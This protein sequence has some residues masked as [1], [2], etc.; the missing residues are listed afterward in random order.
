MGHQSGSLEAAQ[1]FIASKEINAGGNA[2]RLNHPCH[3]HCA[4]SVVCRAESICRTQRL[5]GSRDR[6]RMNFVQLRA[7]RRNDKTGANISLPVLMAVTAPFLK[8]PPGRLDYH[9]RINLSVQS[10][11]TKTWEQ[12]V[13]LAIEKAHPLFL[14]R[15]PRNSFSIYRMSW[16]PVNIRFILTSGCAAEGDGGMW[17]HIWDKILQ[18]SLFMSWCEC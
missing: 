13:E 8:K 4:E 9:W 11:M 1:T 15:C 17:I 2:C 5:V 7:S 10:T 3:R 16:L 12:K 18:Q 14:F 6:R